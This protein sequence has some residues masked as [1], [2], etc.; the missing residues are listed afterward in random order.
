VL[1]HAR[2]TGTPHLNGNFVITHAGVLCTPLGNLFDVTHRY[3][4]PFW[5]SLACLVVSVFIVL[6]SSRIVKAQKQIERN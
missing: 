4:V 2:K 1:G 5:V 6:A 3:E